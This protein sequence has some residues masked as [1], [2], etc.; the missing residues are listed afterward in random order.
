MKHKSLQVFE[1]YKVGCSEFVPLLVFFYQQRHEKTPTTARNWTLV[2][3]GSALSL[4]MSP[5]APYLAT[6][7]AFTIG[8]APVSI[9][10]KYLPEGILV[11]FNNISVR[12]FRV[13]LALKVLP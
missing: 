6:I 7:K 10:T 5:P 4:R 1:T 12:D 2:R 11:T 8:S 9:F 3:Q 13:G